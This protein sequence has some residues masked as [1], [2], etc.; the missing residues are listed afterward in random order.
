MQRGEE[1]VAKQIRAHAAA[2]AMAEK[3]R[4]AGCSGRGQVKA[5]SAFAPAAS[6]DAFRRER[7][8]AIVVISGARALGGNHR[9]A[10]WIFG[11]A[12]RAEGGAIS[13]L[14]E[15]LQDFGANA[16]GGLVCGDSLVP[17][18]RSASNAAYSSRNPRPLWGIPPMPRHLRS[19]TSNTSA[20]NFLREEI[21]LE[22]DGANVLIFD[23]GAAL[24]E[25]GDE[26]EDGLKEIERFKTA[27]D[28]GHAK[29]VDEIHVFLVAHDGANVAG[30]DEALH[31]IAGELRRARM[32]GGTRTCEASMEKFVRPS[33]LACQTAMALA[34]AV[35]S[36]PTAKKTTLRSGL[37]RAN[38]SA[39]VG[40]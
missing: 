9:R 14:L 2:A 19:Q 29:F 27:D 24:L 8:A 10:E 37:A 1:N 30:T 15:A 22:G 23:F 16:F 6:L 20:N 31:A 13:G 12:A 18:M 39:S 7:V 17:K 11:S 36:K 35:V 33:R 4:F 38:L 28:D 5:N 25:L 34:G 40:E 26:H 21:A 32:A 3:D